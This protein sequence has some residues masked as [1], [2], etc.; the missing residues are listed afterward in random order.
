MMNTVLPRVTIG[1]P[2]YN[3]GAALEGAIAS[4]VGQDHGHLE[5]IVCDN[6]STDQTA[7]ICASWMQR[8][9]RIRYH[10]HASNVGAIA[11]F[12]SLPPMASGA[13]FM[14]L[15]DD[16]RITPNYVSECLAVHA[17]HPEA[18]LVSGI[19]QLA[20][21]SGRAAAGVTIETTSSRP[22]LR[23]LKYLLLVR[24]NSGFYG[25]MKSADAR[26]HPM[27]PRLAGDWLLIMV[28]AFKGPLRI[29]P[30]ACLIRSADGQSA[31]FDRLMR[32]HGHS[33]LARAFP[34]VVI[35]NEVRR[36]L[37][38]HPHVVAHSSWLMRGLGSL[39]GG[40][41]IAV[42]QGVFWRAVSLASR[43]L[44]RVLSKQ[45]ADTL[46]RRLRAWMGI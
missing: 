14:W 27:K 24:D 5:I 21:S 42:G 19:S 46:R 44:N 26:L 20:A 30:S 16:D 10:R 36:E 29:A 33:W 1:I 32:A 6:A 17:R 15:A 37:W 28:L 45:R 8:D 39:L 9:S 34:Y 35:G 2:T 18:A 11:N 31:N 7:E 3:R 41:S 4:A 13:Y 22:W 43:L 23:V 12:N 40:L 25:L 38:R